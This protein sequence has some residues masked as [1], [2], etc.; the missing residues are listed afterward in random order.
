M[1][2][3]IHIVTLPHENF[4]PA[5]LLNTLARIWETQGHR[6][7]VG[8]CRLL[9]ADLG[10]LHIDRTRLLEQWLP[11]RQPSV[12]MLNGGVL[13]ISKRRVS[14]NLLSPESDYQGPVIIKTDANCAGLPEMAASPWWKKR[15]H[16]LL[17]HYLPWRWTR[18]LACG[19]YPVLARLA[20]VPRWVWQRPDLVVEKFLPEREG[21]EYAL[22]IWCFFGKQEYGVRMFSRLPFVKLK[23]ITRHEYIDSVPDSLRQ[24]RAAMGMDFGKIDYVMVNGEAVLLDANKTPTVRQSATPSNNMLRLA[25]GL[26]DFLENR[27]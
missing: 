6:I 3:Q 26:A 17:T 12:R 18:Q 25:S 20:C 4:M 10:I 9:Q 21:D 1:G 27:A 23:G 7:T 22:R 24:T 15:L 11:V 2:K 13:D 14:K 8:A 19:S 16:R 5:Y